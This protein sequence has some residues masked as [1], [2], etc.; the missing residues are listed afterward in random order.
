MSILTEEAGQQEGN[1]EE[2]SQDT[3]R[4]GDEWDEYDWTQDWDGSL[5]DWSGDWSWSEDDWNYWCDDWS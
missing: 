2:W 4:Y 5:D 3:E 1:Q